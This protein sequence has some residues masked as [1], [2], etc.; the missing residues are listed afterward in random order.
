MKHI[1]ALVVSALL[2]LVAR[3]TPLKLNRI[4]PELGVALGFQVYRFEAELGADEVLIIRELTED[5]GKV[6]GSEFAVVGSHERAEYEIALVDSG[7]FHP[8]LKNTYMLRY[9]TY[10]GYVENKGLKEWGSSEDTVYFIFSEVDSNEQS[11][12]LTWVGSVEKYSE[13]VKRW[14]DLPK[15]RGSGLSGSRRL[16]KKS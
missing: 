9:P 5:H 8:S 2:C 11:R 16:L 12:K 6:S 4:E 7:A 3:A 13:V 1:I 10:K 15:P 14:P